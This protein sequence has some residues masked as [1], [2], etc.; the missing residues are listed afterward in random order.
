MVWRLPERAMPRSSSQS[1]M[2]SASRLRSKA[3]DGAGYFSRSAFQKTIRACVGRR[4]RQGRLADL[5][6][7]QRFQPCEGR[8][9]RGPGHRAFVDGPPELALGM[10]SRGIVPLTITPRSRPRSEPRPPGR[11]W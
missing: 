10:G 4:R 3:L 6:R 1:M 9:E 5:E 8:L 11:W 7:V 2:A